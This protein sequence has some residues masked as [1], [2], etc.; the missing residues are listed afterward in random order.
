MSFQLCHRLHEVSFPKHWWDPDIC[1]MFSSSNNDFTCN[2]ISF[3]HNPVS[4]RPLRKLRNVE[5][6]ITVRELIG[7][8]TGMWIQLLI[9]L[10][11]L[12]NT[13]ALF[14]V[15]PTYISHEIQLS[16]SHKFMKNIRDWKRTWDHL[17]LPAGKNYSRH[18][19]F[20]FAGNRYSGKH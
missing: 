16:A 7:D 5:L 14:S 8:R 20:I 9:L 17:F 13:T 18:F 4:N 2:Y 10:V 12:P 3:S 1:R 15:I 11:T 19:R 6:F